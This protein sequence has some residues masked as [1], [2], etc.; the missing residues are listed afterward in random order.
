MKKGRKELLTAEE[1]TKAPPKSTPP[2]E[3]RYTS[4]AAADIEALDGSIRLQLRKVI[5][6][7]LTIDPEGY[8]TPLREPLTNYWKHEFATH[9]V[10]YR[11]YTDPRVIAICAVGIRK[12]GDIE[13]VYKQ[14]TAVVKTGRLASQVASVFSNLLPKKK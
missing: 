6:K 7:K 2:F 9:R 12:A 11:I 10:I 5:V 1:K 3:A 8:G 13:D 4:D 14:L